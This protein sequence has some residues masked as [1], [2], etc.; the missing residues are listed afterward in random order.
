MRLLGTLTSIET[1]AHL[2]CLHM[3]ELQFYLKAL[4]SKKTES[5]DKIIPV[6]EE[7]KQDLKWWLGEGRFSVG[8]SLTP[9]NPDLPFF[10]DASNKGWGA[11]LEG[12]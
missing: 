7:I 1:L 12:Q 8:K 10:S 3:R 5:E 4:W 9:A 6:T 11:H 2:G